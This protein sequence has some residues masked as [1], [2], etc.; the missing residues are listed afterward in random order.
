MM[1]RPCQL[2]SPLGESGSSVRGLSCSNALASRWVLKRLAA[3]L[4]RDFTDEDYEALLE[5]DS[6]VARPR[7]SE[8]MLSTLRTHVHSKAP[9]KGKA[10]CS[11][12]LACAPDRS[13]SLV[14]K[15][16]SPVCSYA[17]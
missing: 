4:D 2:H 5:L 7:L 11:T 1:L 13:S 3:C 6:D 16:L 12:P 8:A 10:G 17:C 9:A 15:V 14:E